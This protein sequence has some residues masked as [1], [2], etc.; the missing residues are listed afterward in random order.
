MSKV[1]MFRFILL[2][3]FI[4]R[5]GIA[6]AYAGDS[7]S[8]TIENYLSS[9]NIKAEKTKE[10][11]YY[12]IE[13]DGN[14]AQPK[15]GDYVKMKYT[16]KLLEG[17]MFD[18]SPK[19]EPFVFQVGY[20]QVIQ[21]WDL[22]IPKLKVGTKATLYIPSDF[23]YGNTGIGDVIPPNTPL[24]FEVDLQSVLTSQDYDSH[25]RQL[26]DRE[27]LAFQKQSEEQFVKDKKL[28][29]EYAIA[30]KLKM[31]RTEKGVSYLITKQGKGNS[32]KEGNRLTV[33]YDG[34]LLDDKNF[35]STKDKQPFSFTLGEGKAIEGWEVALKYFNK[36]SEG[37][38][39]IPSKLA[40]GATP[41]EDSSKTLIP[42]N[43]VLI[44]KVQVLDIQQVNQ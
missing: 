27:R 26:E 42:P 24:I 6:A 2:S 23:A 15:Q 38:L 3:T 14:G 20:R 8:L 40:Y 28:I 29:Q 21:G 43:S 44:F 12:T 4:L 5:G 11:I 10:G 34:F 39:M 33:Q 32:A 16:G 25:M 17:K 30:H 1:K 9:K 22:I 18:E 19:D 41:I 36:G 31:S 35:D 7:D 37:Y 13:N